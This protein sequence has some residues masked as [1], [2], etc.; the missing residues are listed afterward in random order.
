MQS[1]P[2][3]GAFIWMVIIAIALIALI[4]GG[5]WLFKDN[6]KETPAAGVDPITAQN[7]QPTPERTGY[8]T[9]V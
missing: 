4:G 6:G 8:K 7:G 1:K 3:S 5:Y 2:R 9:A